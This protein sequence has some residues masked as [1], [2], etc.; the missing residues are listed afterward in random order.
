MN[1]M[2]R[3]AKRRYVRLTVGRKARIFYLLRT[4]MVTWPVAGLASAHG[5]GR[6]HGR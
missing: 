3:E 5:E 1:K 4:R 2:N 6:S